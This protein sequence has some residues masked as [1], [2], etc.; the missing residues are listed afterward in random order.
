[1]KNVRDKMKQL[2]ICERSQALETFAESK[3]RKDLQENDSKSEKSRSSGSDTIAYLCEKAE[4]EFKSEEIAL[5]NGSMIY[6]QHSRKQVKTS[7]N[8]RLLR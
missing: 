4:R 1:M 3:K 5:K 6:L 2:K 8:K 7:N